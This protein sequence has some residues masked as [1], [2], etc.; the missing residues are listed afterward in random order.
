MKFDAKKS[1]AMLG[2]NGGLKNMQHPRRR[3]I[4]SENAKSSWVKRRA[5]KLAQLDQPKP[6]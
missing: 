3:E 6:C 4:N 1:A 5:K 2:R